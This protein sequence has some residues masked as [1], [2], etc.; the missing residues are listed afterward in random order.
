M[1]SSRK[2][3]KKNNKLKSE[4]LLWQKKRDNDVE[5]VEFLT[6]KNFFDSQMKKKWIIDVV[7][8]FKKITNIVVRI[9]VQFLIMTINLLVHF[10]KKKKKNL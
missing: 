8:F 2:V 6:K 10:K 7:F 5:L 1:T 4:N 9:L 3:E